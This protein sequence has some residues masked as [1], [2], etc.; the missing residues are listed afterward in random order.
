MAKVK[1]WT[2]YRFF[3][4]N[5]FDSPDKI[6]SGYNMDQDIIG[7]LEYARALNDVPY[8]IGSGFRTRSWNSHVGGVTKSSH[9]KG[10]A[11]DIECKDPHVRLTMLRNLILAGFKRIIIY[12]TFIH[13]DVDNNKKYGAWLK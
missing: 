3:K 4:P 6:N 5:E 13:C 8:K 10:L 11:A 1:D 9:M 7:R 2:K 12:S